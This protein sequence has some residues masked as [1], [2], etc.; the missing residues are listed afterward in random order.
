[1]LIDVLVIIIAII[2]SLVRLLPVA[3][4]SGSIVSYLVFNDFR[5]NLLFMGFLMNELIALAYN[6]ALKG[7]S[8]S[9]CA[10]LADQSNFYVLP[11]SIT[12][13]IGFFFGF[14][15]ADS[16][17]KNNFRSTAFIL[18]CI[19][20][21]MTIFS[22]VNVGCEGIMNALTFAVLGSFIGMAYYY[23]VRDYYHADLDNIKKDNDFFD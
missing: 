17:Y 14:M 5:G 9:E 3:L 15:M 11:S 8:K 6:K 20:L 18:L 1:M 23:V 21:A 13:T 19:L 16:Y 22:R 12:Q 2:N 4:Y 7:V 10:L